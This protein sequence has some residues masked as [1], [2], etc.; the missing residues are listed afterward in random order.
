MDEGIAK[1][2]IDEIQNE[3]SEEYEESEEEAYWENNEPEEELKKH[4][5]IKSEPNERDYQLEMTRNEEDAR[6]A[7]EEKEKIAIIVNNINKIYKQIKKNEHSPGTD[8]L[9]KNMKSSNLE[10]TIAKLETMNS[11]GAEYIPRIEN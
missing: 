3:E 7:K 5:K 10:R 11:L 6:I 8:Y 1:S 4:E 2:E 9:Y